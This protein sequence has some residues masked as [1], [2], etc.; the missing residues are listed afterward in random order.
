MLC[1]L[2]PVVLKYKDLYPDAVLL[3]PVVLA[4]LRIEY[5][6]DVLLSPV[7]VRI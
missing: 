7:C 5:P 2:F 6:D 3:V 1:Y 4:I